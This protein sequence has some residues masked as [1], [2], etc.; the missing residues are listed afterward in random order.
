MIENIPFL[1]WKYDDSRYQR[2]Q[3]MFEQHYPNF[4]DAGMWYQAL[5][6]QYTTS[7]TR[8]LDLGCGHSSLAAKA[9]SQAEQAVGV[10]LSLAALQR[11]Q[12]IH[13]PTVAI[14]EQL[15]LANESFDLII[16][17]WV[18]EHLPEPLLVLQEIAR[19]LRPNG[20]VILFTTNAYNYIPL[21]SQII[22]NQLQGYLLSHLLHRPSSDSFPTFFRANTVKQLTSLAKQSGLIVQQSL[23]VGNPFYLAF[24]PTLFRLAL[25]FEQVTDWLK[26]EQ[27]KLYLVIQLEKP[28]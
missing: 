20:N 25:L 13:E 1:G 10:D 4:Q 3:T 24:S 27:I 14:G 2:C 5:V 21:V 18:I 7:T 19:V 26:L 6:E 16:S 11:N 12:F 22:P 15:P 17:Q 23:Y 9:I 28:G 8:L